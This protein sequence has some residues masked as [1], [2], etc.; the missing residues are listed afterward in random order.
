[1]AVL[2]LQ[3]AGHVTNNDGIPKRGASNERKKKKE[4]EEDNDR[5]R[6]TFVLF[7]FELFHRDDVGQQR[8]HRSGLHVTLTCTLSFKTHS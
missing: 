2:M 6:Q 7:T 8:F 5:R 4:N 1:M 3:S